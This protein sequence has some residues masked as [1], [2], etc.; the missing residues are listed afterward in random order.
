MC[1]TVGCTALRRHDRGS[2]AQTHHSVRA[3][4]PE[5]LGHVGAVERPE[6]AERADVRQHRA[7]VCSFGATFA[8]LLVGSRPSRYSSLA[9]G[10]AIRATSSGSCPG[11]FR[12][13]S[14]HR[15]V[16]IMTCLKPST[17][18]LREERTS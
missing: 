16:I 1:L 7:E 12:R 5:V 15:V 10:A 18:T 6:V 4:A 8:S 14:D 2:I 9:P 13:L 17:T 11:G 3:S